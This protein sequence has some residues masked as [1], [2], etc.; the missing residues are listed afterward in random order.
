MGSWGARAEQALL[1]RRHRLFAPDLLIPECANILRKKVRR[2]ELSAPEAILAARLLQRA[3]VS[4]EPMRP[5][6]ESAARMAFTLDHPAHD[7]V[8]LA[9]AQ[10][11]SCALVTAD[12]HLVRKIGLLR[13]EAEIVPLSALG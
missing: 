12:E 5:L 13:P 7:C 6:L 2:H 10:S 1:L 9:L 8:Y 4:L 11:L 3:D